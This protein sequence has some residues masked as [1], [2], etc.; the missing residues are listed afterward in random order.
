LKMLPDLCPFSLHWISQNPQPGGP[1]PC[2]YVPSVTRR[3]S[4]TP[5]APGS[6]LFAL[7]DLQEYGGGLLT[8]PHTGQLKYTS[9]LNHKI[10]S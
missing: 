5:K 3:C 9:T 7:Y 4:Y 1:G 6:L 10:N 8:R 2:L